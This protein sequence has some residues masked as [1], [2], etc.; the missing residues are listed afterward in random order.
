MS[1]GA[2]EKQ[3]VSSV[4]VLAANSKLLGEVLVRHLVGVSVCVYLCVL[5]VY[6]S[7]FVCETHPTCSILLLS[8]IIQDYL[9][10]P[11]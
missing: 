8:K 3:V 5:C 9:Y 10:N 6:L 7:V 4:C 1:A 2:T 11:Q